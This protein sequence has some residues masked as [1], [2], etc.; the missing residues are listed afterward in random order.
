MGTKNA[1]IYAIANQKGGIA[2]TTTALNLAAGLK[3]AGKKVLLIDADPQCNSSDTVHAEIHDIETLYD[4][5]VDGADPHT[6]IQHTE[7]CDV[8]P[9][10]PL[11]AYAEAK[12]PVVGR[13]NLLRNAIKQVRGEYE[14][15]I[16]DTPPQLGSML[17][18]ALV[19][20]EKVIVPITPE[21][22]TLQGLSELNR[23]IQLV[24]Q[25]TVNENLKISG[26][27]LVKTDPRRQMA[28][29]TMEILP[30]I[31][32]QMGTRCYK[33]FIREAEAVRKSQRNRMT[34]FQYRDIAKKREDSTGVLKDFEAFVTEVIEEGK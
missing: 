13:D 25:N 33:S 3:L 26:L 5:M 1:T 29:E 12:L 30:G 10:D 9:G 4:I 22:Y 18:N 31:C 28:K 27:L 17:N 19:A 16:I 20:A 23:T 21:R 34:I 8:I 14:Y 11:L 7:A 15:I 2:K 32:E 24:R 6:A